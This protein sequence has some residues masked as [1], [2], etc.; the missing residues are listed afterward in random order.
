MNS[1]TEVETNRLASNHDQN[2][3]I[4]LAGIQDDFQHQCQMTLQL[5][6]WKKKREN[7][8]TETSV[9]SDSYRC[10]IHSST[11]EK[12][13]YLSIPYEIN[14]IS[15]ISFTYN[16]ISFALK[17]PCIK[18]IRWWKQTSIVNYQNILLRNRRIFQG[19]AMNIQSLLR[20][21]V[22]VSE[23]ICLVHKNLRGA[24]SQ[25]LGYPVY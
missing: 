14:P 6:P 16:V 23:C 10:F 13:C 12:N 20:H 1:I 24:C 11:K 7:H 15:N 18:N 17:I 5:E 2:S 3:R 25:F 9:K 22:Q 21:V 19:T 4:V 8:C